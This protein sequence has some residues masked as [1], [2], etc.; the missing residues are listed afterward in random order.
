MSDKIDNQLPSKINTYNSPKAFRFE[1]SF[2]IQAKKELD[3]YPKNKAKSAVLALLHLAQKQN[4]KSN[5][6]TPEAIHFIAKLLS[7]SEL[8]VYGIATFYSMF[9]LQPT[10]KFH[11][12]VC[13]T[14]S[15]ML[16][17]AQKIK[18]AILE[19][20]K[21]KENRVS[22]DG[23]FTVTEVECLGACVNAPVIQVND[24][25]CQN[26]NVKLAIDLIN[27]LKD[28]NLTKLKLISNPP[29]LPLTEIKNDR[30]IDK[31]QSYSQIK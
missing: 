17:G 28:N 8:S 27:N 6:I 2:A 22:E 19:H 5:Y 20:L 10:G 11:I 9:R 26:L 30:T 24:D 15:C 21:I 25:F 12:Q 13:G 4:I 18:K 1:E 31:L 7:I 29:S 23:L 3:K 16:C 14:T